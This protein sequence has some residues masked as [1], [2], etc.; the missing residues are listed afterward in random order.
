MQLTVV[1]YLTLTAHKTGFPW[2]LNDELG[3]REMELPFL[4]V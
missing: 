1:D 3:R 4:D 2:W